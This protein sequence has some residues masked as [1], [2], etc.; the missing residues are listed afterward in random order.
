MVATVTKKKY[1]WVQAV[2]MNA[3]LSKTNFR[4]G[5]GSVD[6]ATNY[7]TRRSINGGSDSNHTGT[8]SMKVN[9]HVNE[10]ASIPRFLN[11]FIINNSSNEKLAICHYSTAGASGAGSAP[12]RVES[13]NKWI[14]TSGQA[15]TLELEA[16]SGNLNSGSFMKVW[17]AD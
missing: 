15:D 17:G 1:L 11:M 7:A 4:L 14:N 5:D 16:S 6:I 10:S 2:S 12:T 13:V 3:S 9:G 8:G